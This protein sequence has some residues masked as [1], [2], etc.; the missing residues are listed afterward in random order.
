MTSYYGLKAWTADNKWQLHQSASQRQQQVQ[1]N[2]GRQNLQ[3]VLYFVAHSTLHILHSRKLYPYIVY[4]RIATYNSTTSK[5][6]VVSCLFLDQGQI[7]FDPKLFGDESQ[8]G[9]GWHRL[10]WWGPRGSWIFMFRV[11]SLDGF[12]QGWYIA[13]NASSLVYGW[14][15]STDSAKVKVCRTAGGSQREETKG[16]SFN[17]QWDVSALGIC[18]RFGWK[19]QIFTN[20]EARLSTA[21]KNLAGSMTDHCPPLSE[22]YV[23]S[24]VVGFTNAVMTRHYE[25]TLVISRKCMQ[26][27]Y[28]FLSYHSVSMV[29]ESIYPSD[30]LIVHAHW[31]LQYPTSNMFFLELICSSTPKKKV[32]ASFGFAL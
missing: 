6:F 13:A 1:D 16:R 7:L 12:S 20:D 18:R 30:L 32:N 25:S 8:E 27:Q 14:C 2:L 22:V 9:R 29:Y 10:A 19:A 28:K 3:T 23:D 4:D 11:W 24:P 5:P 17:I 26:I 15:P 21:R 31:R